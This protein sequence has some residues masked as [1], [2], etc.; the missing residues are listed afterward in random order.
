MRKLLVAPF[1]F[2]WLGILP[3]FSQNGL[4]QSGPM[5]GYVDMKEALLWAQTTRA[6]TVEFVY[7]DK[8]MPKKKYV[9]DPV[10][11]EKSTAYTAK[12]IADQVEPGRQYAYELRINGKAV[13]LPYPTE[14]KTQPL[15][16]WRTDPPA[17][18][19]ATG[20]CAYMNEP[21]YDRPGKPYGSNFQIFPSI[22]GQ[23]PDLMLWLGDNTYLRE[24]DW[25]TRTGV[26]HRFTHSRS[27]PEL[28][29][30]LASTSHYAIWD[31]HDFGPNDS[32]GSWI[33]KDMTWDV[34]RAFWGNPTFGVNGQKGCTTWFQYADVDFFLLDDR[35]FRTPNDCATCPRTLLGQEQLDWFK[36][37]LA[38][39][40]APFKIVAIGGQVLSTLKLNERYIN[41]FPAE[42]DSILAHIE[43][44]DIKGVVFLTGDVHLTELSAL[45]N[46]RG[47]WVYDLTASPLTSGVNTHGKPDDNA[48][49]V[50]GTLVMQHN[51]AMLRF[52]GPRKERQL[53]IAVYSSDGKEIWKKT[54]LPTGVL[55]N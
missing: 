7:W 44:E 2:F 54:I 11:T 18:S 15:W 33:H 30:L 46:A 51:F 5:L 17:F 28:Q 27:L 48:N 26:L 19:V 8:E 40:Q 49:R 50:D 41:L 43:R 21:E 10:K 37:A 39:S 35:Y 23:K 20:S 55:G 47:N 53:E 36:A 6:A 13:A 32:D 31:D 38:Q 12:C 24:P 4:L 34:F 42:R 22:A 29:P 14:F 16:R 1:L 45:Q 25:A 9:T 52:S 3:L